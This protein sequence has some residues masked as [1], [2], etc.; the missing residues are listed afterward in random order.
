[1]GVINGDTILAATNTASYP[2]Y[3]VKHT[4]VCMTHSHSSSYA[5][6]HPVGRVFEKKTK[7]TPT[8]C[9]KMVD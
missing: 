3:S 9:G 1:M 7:K 2:R 8:Q 4:A 6:L 5:D